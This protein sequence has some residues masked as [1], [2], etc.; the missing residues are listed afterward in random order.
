MLQHDRLPLSGSTIP[1]T[2]SLDKGLPSVEHINLR[3]TMRM[4]KLPTMA[5]TL[6]KLIGIKEGTAWP[7]EWHQSRS[8]HVRK[9][10]SFT[11]TVPCHQP[12]RKLIM[13]MADTWT[14]HIDRAIK[15]VEELAGEKAMAKD[16]GKTS[17]LC[18]REVMLIST[19]QLHQELPYSALPY[20]TRVLHP[21]E[22]L[23]ELLKARPRRPRSPQRLPAE[24]TKLVS[25]SG[26]D[27]LR[28]CGIPGLEV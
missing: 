24:N 8:P 14:I 15:L 19:K 11:L 13:H 6:G 12:V 20:M 10:Q 25:C 28:P 18:S 27:D 26:A 21:S 2:D 5:T 7:L 17:S 16:A 23:P 9:V 22:Q 3:M 4:M 1:P